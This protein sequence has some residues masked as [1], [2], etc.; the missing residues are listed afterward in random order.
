[1][2]LSALFKTTAHAS[3]FLL[4]F[5]LARSLLAVVVRSSI[6]RFFGAGPDSDAYFAAFTIPQQIGDLFIGGILMAVI[7]PVFQDRRANAGNASAADD[8]AGLLNLSLLAMGGLTAVYFLFIPQLVPVLFP[9][10][11]EPTR[12]LTISLSRWL[13]PALVLMGL[14]LVYVSFYHAHRDFVTPAVAT[15]FFPLS[16][17]VALWLLPTEW[18]IYRLAYGNLAGSTLGL[19]LLI[20]CI[21]SRIPWRWRWR[22]WNPVVQS[23]VLLAWP[24]LLANLAAKLVPFA[25]KNVASTLGGGTITLLDYALFLTEAILA[26]IVAPVATAVYPLL[27]EQRAKDGEAAMFDTYLEA[28]RVV[29][30]L[31]IPCMV[32]QVAAAKDITLMLF[33][34]GKFSADDAAVCARLLI[35]TATMIL[36]QCLA[37]LTGRVFFAIQETKVPAAAGIAITLIALPAYFFFGHRF[38]IYGLAGVWS[39]TYVVVGIVQLL[40]LK[41]LR[42]SL[43]LARLGHGVTRLAV[44][45][46]AMA[47]AMV[48]AR[49]AMTSIAF[50]PVRLITMA[51]IGGGTYLLVAHWLGCRELLFVL[52]RMPVIGQ[53]TDKVF[54]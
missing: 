2:K 33:G 24:M 27:G 51:A 45:A 3:L 43:P 6:A 21:H 41:I 50:A 20:G 30:F 16:S 8:V 13:A 11:D 35:I 42:R 31:A 39:G 28:L 36:P 5:S 44:A 38:G 37:A 10:F 48:L 9:G 46:I 1:M 54:P 18:G 22:C 12:L 17:L 15:L 53:L 23:V 32:L 25:Q 52:R 26:F 29:L 14:S 47:G 19:A 7:I 4:A 34:Y 49:M 40:M